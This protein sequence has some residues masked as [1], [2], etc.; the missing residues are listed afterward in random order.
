MIRLAEGL[1]ADGFEVDL[2][3]PEAQAR[4]TSGLSQ[5]ARPSA[6][7][8]SCRPATEMPRRQLYTRRL[9]KNARWVT[10]ARRG[11]YDIVDAWLNPTDVFA[12]LSRPL[13]RV[14]VVMSA[15]LDVLPGALRTGD[16]PGGGRVHRQTDIVVANADI[17]PSRPS[18]MACRRKGP[19]HPR[20]RRT[21]ASGSPLPSGQ[22]SERRS[23]SRTATSSSAAW[24][25]SGP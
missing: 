5:P 1:L 7:S 10:A 2:V 15:R 21:A 18:D 12:A 9:T 23:G 6:T 24:E 13:T 20:R 19:H 8:V 11:R 22:L 3:V 14:P 17:T 25:P 4:S 16:V